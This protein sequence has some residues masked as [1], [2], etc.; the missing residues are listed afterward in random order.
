MMNNHLLKEKLTSPELLTTTL[1]NEFKFLVNNCAL[2]AESN[3]YFEK[4]LFLKN[5]FPIKFNQLF[6]DKMNKISNGIQ[7][8]MKNVRNMLH[9]RYRYRYIGLYFTY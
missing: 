7:T 6:E 1:V 5:E 4:A 2:N 9:N 3:V 8:R